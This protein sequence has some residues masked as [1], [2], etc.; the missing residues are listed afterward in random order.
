MPPSSPLVLCVDDDADDLMFITSLLQKADPSLFTAIAHDGEEALAYLA[1]GKLKGV[2]PT[3]ILMDINMPR[4]NGKV[5]LA[6]I[7]ADPVL[8]TIPVVVF[9][10]SSLPSDRLYCAHYG[11]EMVSKPDTMAQMQQVLQKLLCQTLY[12]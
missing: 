4:M 1:K 5:A 3:L 7:K 2:L 11:V 12:S 8:Q 10:T 9:T 6:H